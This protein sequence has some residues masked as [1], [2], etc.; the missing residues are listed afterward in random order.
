MR[1]SESQDTNMSPP[2]VL[3]LGEVHGPAKAWLVSILGPKA[4]DD[5]EVRISLKRPAVAVLDRPWTAELND[6]RCDLIDKDLAGALTADEELELES[7]TA[8]MRRYVDR[9]APIPIQGVRD[10]HR[11]LLEQA[12]HTEASA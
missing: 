10:L 12:R 6:R 11:Q 9:V 4:T 7:L 2:T 1:T 3:R 5:A 8:E